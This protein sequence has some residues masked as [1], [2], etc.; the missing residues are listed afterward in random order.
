MYIFYRACSHSVS[1]HQDGE[2]RRLL[3][4]ACLTRLRKAQGGNR[5]AFLTSLKHCVLDIPSLLVCGL[6]F[7]P[8]S[9]TYLHIKGQIH[10]PWR[11]DVHLRFMHNLTQIRNDLS[12]IKPD[13]CLRTT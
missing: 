3:Q 8:I 2:M 7:H 10:E 6:G 13:N 5:T 4:P 9:S 11:T 12:K 1:M